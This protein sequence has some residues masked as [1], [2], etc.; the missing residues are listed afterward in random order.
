MSDITNPPADPVCP[1]CFGADI[2]S[3]KLCADCDFDECGRCLSDA[4]AQA[5]SEAAWDRQQERGEADIDSTRES[6]ISAGRRHLVG[7]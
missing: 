3:L 1:K 4:A 2:D 7:R 5:R 6:L